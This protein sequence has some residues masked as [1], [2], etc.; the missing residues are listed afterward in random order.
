MCTSDFLKRQLA[1]DKEFQS[2]GE[3][4]LLSS[5][6]RVIVIVS[7]IVIV[8]SDC[9]VRLQMWKEILCHHNTLHVKGQI[10]YKNSK[11]AQTPFISMASEELQMLTVLVVLTRASGET[12]ATGG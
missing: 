12:K 8:N 5:A 10:P 2:K 4:Y 6:R 11:E 7:V 3:R 1:S 9:M